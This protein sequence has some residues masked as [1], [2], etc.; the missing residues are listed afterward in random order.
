MSSETST[1]AA[2]RTR[3]WSLDVT[4]V[5]SVMGVV[6]IHVFAEMVGN[7]QIRGTGGWWAAVAADIGFVWVVPVFVMISGALIL[8][9]RHYRDGPG[10]FYRR[11]LPRLAT[12]LVVWSLFY[13]VVIR[14]LFS[15]VPVTRVDLADFVLGGKPYT[16]LYF[17]WL[18]IG[19]YAVAPI[20]AS[21]LRGG[22]T[23]RAVVFAGSVLAV[24]V[25]T[26]MSSSVLGG[27]GDARPLTL[28]A[29]TQWL[30]YTGYFLAGW[31]LRNVRLSGVRL[32][33]ASLL[34]LA[35]LGLSIWQYGV[36]PGMPLLD[37][38]APLSYY[39]PVVAMAS[40]GVFVC[41]N[42]ALADWGPGARSRKVLR[43]LSD[44]AF[45]VFL[46]HFAIMVVL[47]SI[48]PFSRAE[49]SFLLSLL[50]WFVV[51]VLSFAVVS[52]MRRVPGVR[53]VV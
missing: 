19:L 14:T 38:V 26:G 25:V 21:F 29:L 32:V 48:D 49:G 51:V 47:R 11:R 28:L 50:E 37:A 45:G 6:A 12:A 7:G 27:M 20:L 40:I 10:P 52:L 35:A 41:L 4:R 30:P 34:T 36:R 39:G 53:R 9:P 13:F 46:V 22:G 17:L 33:V 42:S 5:I 8:E 3:Q 18:I 43:E 16:H 2:S 44:C 24:T 1:G 31:A 23:R 15:Q